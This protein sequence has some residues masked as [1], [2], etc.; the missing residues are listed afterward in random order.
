MVLTLLLFGGLLITGILRVLKLVLVEK[1][2]QQ[3]F[4]EVALTLG[5][6]IPRIEHAILSDE[7]MPELVN[8]FFDVMT[9]QKSWAKILLDVPSAILQIL[10]GLVL[11]AF[12]SPILLAFDLVI[13]AGLFFIMFGLSGGGI[14]TSI[15]ESKEKYHVAEWLEELARCET[16]FKMCSIPIY[17]MRKTDALVVRYISARRSHFRVI[18][19]Q[20]ISSYVF[21]A[22]ASAGILG[23]GGFLV[24]ERQL[25]LGQLVAAEI[26]VVIV[27][28]A[29]EKLVRS[30][31]TFFDL[32]T[33]LHKVGHIT[34]LK[35]ERHL[36][37]EITWETP[38][39]SVS[40]E[41]VNFAYTGASKLF[42]DLSFK[43]APGERVALVGSSGCGKSTL[44]ALVC[45]LQTPS[46]G[47]IK[48]NG[49][50]VADIS[51]RTL[52]QQVALVSDAN[53]IF[54]GTI[55]EN[56]TIG[57]DFVSHT[58]VLWALQITQ[59]EGDI[60]KFPE[61]LKTDLVSAGKNLSKGQMQRILIA[62]A[63][64]ERPRLLILDEAFTGI[65]ERQ[66][67]AIMANLF[68]RNNQW[69]ILNI[70]H[71]I[72]TV[73]ECDTAMVLAEGEIVERGT[74]KVLLTDM[75]SRLSMLF[76]HQS[77]S[78]AV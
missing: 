45:R 3:T 49:M 16:S 29:A 56:I 48:L 5:R 13:F 63:I 41:G 40:F 68:D 55:E 24:I 77:R 65:D 54:E 10:I 33:G 39:V 18:F 14:K 21:Q 59:L 78:F 58:D 42:S 75:R 52:R 67:L 64:V 60:A 69:T 73:L 38:G 19:R 9:I 27:M 28:T 74:P 12:Y 26:I 36:G 57:R 70:S 2:Q 7:Y 32:V 20:A 76:C 71:D 11:M 22:F 66:K 30:L 1:I 25:T 34:D 17:L 37:E 8:R 44:A 43:I 6:K 46:H 35:T 61:G 23:I 4:A 62:R 15:D 31:E 72:Q 50:D 47:S 53:E 51:L